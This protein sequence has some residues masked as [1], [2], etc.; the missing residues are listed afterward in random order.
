MKLSIIMPVYNAE[1]Y[2]ERTVQCVQSQ[3]MQNFEL[4]LVDD[5]STDASGELCDKFLTF[6]NRIKVIHQ[7][8]KGI[9]AARNAGLACANGEY[10]GFVDNDDLIHPQMFEILLHVA[11]KEN[12]DIVMLRPQLV[13]EN[14]SVSDKKYDKRSIMYHAMSVEDMY[15]NLFASN[16]QDTPFQVVWNKIYKYNIAK[17]FFFPSYGTDDSVY[18]CHMYHLAERIFFLDTEPGFYYWIQ[19]K[20]SVSHSVFSYFQF[21]ELQ[22]YL[23]MLQFLAEYEKESMGYGLDKTYKILFR[24]RY[25]SKG[26]D[27]ERRVNERIRKNE[28]SFRHDFYACKKITIIKKVAYSVFY[29]FPCTYSFMRKSIELYVKYKK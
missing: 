13:T 2:L 20:N 14:F 16:L 19:R 7:N 22:S 29:Y 12:A 10:V 1:K 24:A 15:R 26:T 23:D 21:M 6:D 28:K 11:E 27:W 5:G 9:G 25:N 8:N 3:T 18:N 4:I 17:A